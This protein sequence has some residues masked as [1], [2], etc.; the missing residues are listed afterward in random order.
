MT[1][2]DTVVLNLTPMLIVMSVLA[3]FVVRRSGL[4]RGIGGAW[5]ATI[6]IGLAIAVLYP[7]YWAMDCGWLG[8]LRTGVGHV[9]AI[10]PSFQECSSG[11]NLPL[12]LVALPPLV[13]ITILLA[14]VW[15]HVRPSAEAMQAIAILAGCAIVAVLLGQLNENLALL[16]VVAVAAATYLRPRLQ[17][18]HAA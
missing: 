11:N 2:L 6:V 12:W 4:R 10:N 18:Q 8:L 1:W 16:F 9:T 17:R 5:L 3:I 7:N 15:R 13:G 14:W